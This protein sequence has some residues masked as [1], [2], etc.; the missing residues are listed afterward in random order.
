MAP[1]KYTP[2]LLKFGG[3]CVAFLAG[4]VVIGY[5]AHLVSRWGWWRLNRPGPRPMMIRTWHGW[6]DSTKIKDKRQRNR[7]HKPPPYI[8]RTS[9][10]N[11]NWIFWDPTG[12]LQRK[13]NQ[14]KE[15]SLIRWI[16]KWIRSSPVGSA[17]PGIKSSDD[18]EAS[19]PSV[20]RGSDE[21]SRSE[22]QISLAHLGR[23]WH[24]R[25]RKG[26]TWATSS[27]TCVGDSEYDLEG[28]LSND[29]AH[30]HENLDESTTTIRLRK[31]KKHADS[32]ELD[33]EDIKRAS[34]TLLIKPTAVSNLLRLFRLPSTTATSPSQFTAIEPRAEHAQ[35]RAQHLPPPHQLPNNQYSA[36]AHDGNRHP[37]TTSYECYGT[38]THILPRRLS[39][40]TYG[41]DGSHTTSAPRRRFGA[42][43]YIRPR[44]ASDFIIDMDSGNLR[45]GSFDEPEI[46]I[47]RKR[48][49]TRSTGDSTRDAEGMSVVDTPVWD[50]RGSLKDEDGRGKS[51]E[52]GEEGEVWDAKGYEMDC[53]DD[54]V[55]DVTGSREGSWRG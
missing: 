37:S 29:T 26:R 10:T 45:F 27:D 19:R 50:G 13:F 23:R 7:L 3:Y 31:P 53:G 52:D 5:F 6:V 33:S 43:N 48:G 51:W 35:H 21:T 2:G 40:W 12:D 8:P 39:T 34:N 24:R 4:I 28:Q 22:D 30:D 54:G 42:D 36:M 25:W 38:A 47:P 44:A 17:E 46:Y 1:T 55:S 16:P 32:Y 15:R 49:S 20:A 41:L 14:E 11:Y 18:I 9:A